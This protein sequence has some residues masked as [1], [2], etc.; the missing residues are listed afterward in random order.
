MD[1]DDNTPL[2]STLYTLLFQFY[3]KICNATHHKLN[4]SYLINKFKNLLRSKQYREIQIQNKRGTIK[5][6]QFRKP[7]DYKRK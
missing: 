5:P 4:N 2:I 3:K 6:M 7:T 1:N